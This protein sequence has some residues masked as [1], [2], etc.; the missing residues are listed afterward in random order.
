MNIF[1]IYQQLLNNNK[2]LTQ[3]PIC[4][5]TIYTK[6]KKKTFPLDS[7]NNFCQHSKNTPNLPPISEATKV[8]NKKTNNYKQIIVMKK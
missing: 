2:N 7:P 5:T 4:P 1:T 6:K 8:L 3:V